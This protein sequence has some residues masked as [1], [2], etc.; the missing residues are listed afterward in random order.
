LKR[1]GIFSK[2]ERGKKSKQCDVDMSSMVER[3]DLCENFSDVFE[4]VKKSAEYSLGQR[5][6]GL[7]LYLARLPKHI[8]AFHT[9]GTNGIVMNRTTLDMVTHGAR[10]LREINSYVYS[11]LL[12]EY[13]HSLGYVEERDVRKLVYDVSLS[14]FGPDHPATQ[15]AAKGPSVVFP[16][17]TVSEMPFETPDV[18]VVPDIERSSHKYI[19]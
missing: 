9:L 6:A 7:M 8:G 4:L 15:I 1:L 11:I 2:K 12:H 16:E 13:L 3:L 5:R 18:E 17:I 14:T 10:S 19:S